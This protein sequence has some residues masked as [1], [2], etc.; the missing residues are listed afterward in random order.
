[1]SRKK[2]ITYKQKKQKNKRKKKEK[3]SFHHLLEAISI[4]SKIH[5]TKHTLRALISNVLKC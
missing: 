5:S 4:L 1:M 3:K 2:K